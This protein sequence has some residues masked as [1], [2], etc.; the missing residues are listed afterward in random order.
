MKISKIMSNQKVDVKKE[1]IT[2]VEI[3][4][5]DKKFKYKTIFILTSLLVMLIIGANQKS[6]MLMAVGLFVGFAASLAASLASLILIL[7][8]WDTRKIEKEKDLERINEL[9]AK[10]IVICNY[11]E[12]VKKQGRVPII[13]ELIA[14]EAQYAEEQK[15][16]IKH[17]FTQMESAME[18]DLLVNVDKSTEADAK[19]MRWLLSGHGYF[20]EENML[21]GHC[22]GGDDEG[23]QDDARRAIDEA[24]SDDEARQKISQ[25]QTARPE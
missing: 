22:F 15:E 4:K 16:V 25:K 3:E 2:L 14:M 1:A 12:S 21:C 20:M 19:R 8:T 10:S 23:E 24:I 5:E 11:V 17:Y 18:N 9:K 13:E 6:M 7:S